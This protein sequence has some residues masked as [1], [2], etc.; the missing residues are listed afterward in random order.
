M[1]PIV[2]MIYFGKEVAAVRM[3]MNNYGTTLC[4]RQ[5]GRIAYEAV[6]DAFDHGETVV[7]DFSGVDSVT[8]SFADELFGRL[9]LQL[10][11][12]K[13]KQLTSFVNVNATSARFIRSVMERRAVTAL[14]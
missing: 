3:S 11:M 9:A 8:N 7:F 14:R 2:R 1:V 10:G 5:S 12:E 6:M 13:L 4:T